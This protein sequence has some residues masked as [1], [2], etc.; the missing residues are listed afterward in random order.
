MKKIILSIPLLLLLFNVTAEAC[1]FSSGTPHNWPKRENRVGQKI[2]MEDITLSAIYLGVGI[3]IDRNSYYLKPGFSGTFI[4][5]SNWGGSINGKSAGFKAKNMPEDFKPRYVLF[6]STGT[7]IDR[8]SIISFC[9]LREFASPTKLIR[10]GIESGPSIVSYTEA[11]FQRDS[12]SK[13]TFLTGPSNYKTTYK[14]KETFGLAIRA[15]FEV[16]LTRYA[17]VEFA[18]NCTLN[19]LHNFFSAEFQVNIGLVREKLRPRK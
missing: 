12:I 11:E 5:S 15:K 9:V 4:L 13:P 14:L 10:F 2:K 8:I 6:F 3:K 19:S 7:P 17:G 18:A 1:S 16:P